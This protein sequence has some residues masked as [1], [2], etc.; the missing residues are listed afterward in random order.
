M[1]DSPSKSLWV[2]Y[3]HQDGR[4]YYY[5]QTTRQTVWQKPDELKTPK[6]LALEKSP[7]K[8]YT[9]PEGK[10]YYH[11]ATSKETVWTMPEEYKVL[12]DE[13]AEETKTR[14]G[15]KAPAVTA[16]VTTTPLAATP[17]H[18]T[19]VKPL[20]P[21][22]A[23]VVSIPSPLR[24]QTIIPGTQQPS[25]PLN[26]PQQ[27]QQQQ[28]HLQTQSQPQPLQQIQHQQPP[29]HQGAPLPMLGQDPMRSNGPPFIPTQNPSQRPQFHHQHGPRPR[30]QQS[31][32]PTDS[33]NNRGRERSVNETPEFATKEEAEEAFKN[34]LKE[35]GVTSTW[36]WEQTMRAVV[37]NPMY[38]ALKTTAERKAAFQEYVDERRIQEKQ[39]DK[40]RQQ[41]Q[42]QDFLDLLKSNEKIT[43]ASRYTTVSRLLADEPA[44]KA[45]TDD[46]QR[47]R[48]FD[49]YVSELIRQEKE[50]SRR[51]RK[52][53]MAALLSILQSMDEITLTTRWA[54]AK[55]L[56]QENK[57]F[58]ESDLIQS[59]SKV[60]R[61]TVYEDHI[62]H[63]EEK[64]DQNRAR[65]RTLRKR[66]ERKRREAFKDL[67]N[68]LKSKGQLN[69]KTY[70]MQIHPLIK[71]DPRY[72][73][74]LGQ[75]GSTPMELFWDLVEDLDEKLYQDRKMV[76]DLLRNINYEILPESKFEEFQ[77][78]I[79]KQAKVSHLTTD[80]L[81]LIFEQLLGKVLH[82]AKEE[83]RRQEKL[84]RKKAESFRSMLR[85]LNP[86]VTVES[87]WDDVRARAEST[88]EYAALETDEK[89][90]EVFDR[91]IERLKER[92]SK[93]YDSDD[94]DGS[95][96]EDDADYYG[97]RSMSDRKRSAPS[98]SRHHYGNSSSSTGHHHH[99][100]GDHHRRSITN[101]REHPPSSESA[102]DSQPNGKNDRDNA[103]VRE[104]ETSEDSDR[105]A[106]KQKT[107]DEQEPLVE[108][109]T[110]TEAAL[111]SGTEEGEV[112]ETP[113][114]P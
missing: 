114:Q 14:E 102:K 88:A 53:G 68:E 90:K 46:R 82:H 6:E 12:L 27:Q 5:H 55:D 20:T 79:S 45:I 72:Q 37:T 99:S 92:I 108:A 33:S 85:S 39:E 10:K 112:I 8:E 111:A 106:K 44:F 21:T 30:F 66:A 109:A 17:P 69:A 95:I 75:P 74:I 91:Y 28:I 48:I 51:K 9:T 77:N 59:L 38:R 13:L 29:L 62:K 3:T 57:E 70:W 4:K 1:A 83:K 104:A 100:N 43:H 87:S 113:G 31:F 76:Q 103:N 15:A 78:L 50:E 73:D 32:V 80:D 61:L 71:D 65:E 42:K 110:L 105:K 56:L 11:N 19:H 34:M 81:R 54:E 7:W 18:Q 93:N 96:L 16:V 24:H 2:E 47:Y 58:K 52:A 98:N 25:A 49:G 89:R 64:Y 107:V 40:A 101:T 97:K 36:T 86:A 94:E 63:L 26:P 41:K 22:S 60:N 67:L 84:A 23:S 35:T